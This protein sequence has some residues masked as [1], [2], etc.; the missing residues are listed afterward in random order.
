MNHDCTICKK[1]IE[2]G[3]PVDCYS[4]LFP[5][6]LTCFLNLIPEFASFDVEKRNELTHE[7]NSIFCIR[8]KS[9]EPMNIVRDE[10][11]W[12]HRDRIDQVLLKLR[13]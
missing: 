2:G 12:K 1:E 10:K 5:F 11:Y 8:V 6:H 4:F 13:V 3:M 7:L 9:L